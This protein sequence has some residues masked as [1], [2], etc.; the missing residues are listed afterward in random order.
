[1]SVRSLQHIALAVPDPRS[2][3]S[4]IRTSGWR[5]RNTTGASSCAA[6]AATRIRSCSSRARKAHAP[7][8]FGTRTEDLAGLKKRLEQNGTKLL[9]APKETP[10][11]GIWFRDRT[12]CW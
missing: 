7:C 9:D 11:D 8:P 12:A 10:Y 4:S 3:R 1:M 6:T 5:G 2:A